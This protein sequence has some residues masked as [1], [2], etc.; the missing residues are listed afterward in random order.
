MPNIIVSSSVDQ[1]MQSADSAAARS[2]LGLGDSALKNVG[3]GAAQVA[4]GNHTHAELHD[5]ATVSG[6]GV[7]IVGQQI[8]LDIGTGAAQVA[9][10]NHTHAQ[11][12]DAATVSGNG[13]SI[14]GQQISL[15]IGTGAAQVASG[16]HTHAQLHDAATVS[17]NGVSI[18]GQQISLDIG[19]G[20]A[21]V[22]SGN[23]THSSFVGDTGAG[24]SAGFVPAPASGDAA[25]GKYLDAD[26]TWTIPKSPFPTSEVIGASAS[27]YPQIIITSTADEA[28]IVL[29]VTAGDVTAQIADVNASGTHYWI[30]AYSTTPN[31]AGQGNGYISL[32]NPT[33]ITF[34][35]ALYGEPIEQDNAQGDRALQLVLGSIYHIYSPAPKVWRVLD[36]SKGNADLITP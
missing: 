29:D 25:A 33:G 26:G 3:T 31:G 22:A 15:D 2:V 19:T 4:S 28:L 36:A 32:E 23:H 17:G 6:N 34:Y 14:T 20:A 13:V 5:A 24:G 27:A 35:G 7:S 18:T 10:G 12:H 8:S 21:Q 16:N 11:L 9:S 1:F 30:Q